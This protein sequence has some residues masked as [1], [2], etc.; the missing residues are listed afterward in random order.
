MSTKLIT[1][2]QQVEDA[3]EFYTDRDRDAAIMKDALRLG[4]LEAKAGLS[5]AMKVAEKSYAEKVNARHKAGIALRVSVYDDAVASLTADVAFGTMLSLV[6]KH[7]VHGPPV[8]A[9]H[10]SAGMRLESGLRL[11]D[12]E[13]SS[14]SFYYG[15]RYEDHGHLL[16]HA[17]RVACI[18][19]VNLCEDEPSSDGQ[20][21]VEW[22]CKLDV[23]LSDRSRNLARALVDA[24]A[25]VDDAL[26]LKEEAE[27][28]LQNLD[29]TVKNVE[30]G[31]LRARLQSDPR[32]Q[33]ALDL[34]NSSIACVLGGDITKLLK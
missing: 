10:C 4:K 33:M 19:C 27:S 28:R 24:N 14:T 7:R 30:A 31:I 6:N 2:T 20:S 11:F 17:R 15:E 8:R 18:V 25:A 1:T 5:A 16:Q 12:S 32:S 26:R 22:P 9:K 23:P 29:D 13:H 3:N 34:V 21:R